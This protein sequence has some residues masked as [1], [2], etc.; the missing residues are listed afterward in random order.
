MDAALIALEEPAPVDVQFGQAG[1]PPSEED[2]RIAVRVHVPEREPKRVFI[3][4][5]EALRGL[6][7]AACT[8]VEEEAVLRRQ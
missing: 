3:L 6:E 7:E 4:R 2:L 5:R 8:I 1:A